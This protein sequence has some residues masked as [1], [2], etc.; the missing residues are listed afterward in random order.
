MR[1][2]LVCEQ[3]PYRDNDIISWFFFCCPLLRVLHVALANLQKFGF[4]AHLIMRSSPSA[5][6]LVADLLTNRLVHYLLHRD[7][8]TKTQRG[9]NRY[10][11]LQFLAF[12]LDS[13]VSL[14]R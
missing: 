1:D 14:S 5:V 8:E 2:S 3:S 4:E 11:R 13:M 6:H 9:R 12:S 10:P 7:D